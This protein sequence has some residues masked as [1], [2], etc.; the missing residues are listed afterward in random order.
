M[1]KNGLCCKQTAVLV[2]RII[3]NDVLTDF[4][5]FLSLAACCV[6]LKFPVYNSHLAHFCS[7]R[8]LWFVGREGGGGTNVTLCTFLP[9][10]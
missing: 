1:M 8:K 5:P 3:N 10:C 4:E 7:R 9:Y 6:P 2:V